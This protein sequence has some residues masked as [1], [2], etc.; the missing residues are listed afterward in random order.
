MP[1]FIDDWSGTK[2][3]C[4]AALTSGEGPTQP[5]ISRAGTGVRDELPGLQRELEVVRRIGAPSA[6]SIVGGRLI[7][8]LLNFDNWEVP[9]VLG[10]S[11]AKA[12]QPNLNLSQDAALVR[13]SQPHIRC[14]QPPA[15]STRG[16]TEG[17]LGQQRPGGAGRYPLGGRR[18][19]RRVAQGAAG[20]NSAHKT[21]RRTHSA[22]MLASLMIFAHLA[23]SS[24]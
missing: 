17:H 13:R 2:P 3:T 11:H 8:R 15:W 23:S 24:L 19:D 16:G 1:G 18:P 9:R 7:K 10:H 14:A 4:V 20:E 5:A 22:L 21:P 12:A 6:Q